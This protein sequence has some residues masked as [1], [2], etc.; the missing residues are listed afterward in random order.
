MGVFSDPGTS[1]ETRTYSKGFVGRRT[2]RLASLEGTYILAQPTHTNAY[3]YTRAHTHIHI[4]ISI[5]VSDI[6]AF[7]ELQ[8]RVRTRAVHSR[9]QQSNRCQ[10]QIFNSPI[11]S[12][13]QND[14]RLSA[15]KRESR[16]F[17]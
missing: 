13:R 12:I 4:H 9:R 16:S 1:N 7:G 10:G 11:V 17:F 5:H 8:S 14:G 15:I 3:E 2:S 6:Y